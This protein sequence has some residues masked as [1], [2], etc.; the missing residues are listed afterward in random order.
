MARAV[1]GRARPGVRPSLAVWTDCPGVCLVCVGVSSRVVAYYY[2][3]Q[4]YHRDEGL[5]KDEALA[6]EV[7]KAFGRHSPVI[8]TLL[9][10]GYAHIHPHTK[11]GPQT[12]GARR[13]PPLEIEERREGLAVEGRWK[14]REGTGWPLSEPPRGVVWCVGVL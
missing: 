1:E 8:E 2:A 11:T 9:A 5:P 14:G 12:L 10:H 4:E 13:P 7:G 3:L 6:H